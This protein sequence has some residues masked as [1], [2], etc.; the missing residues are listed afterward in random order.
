MRHANCKPFLAH[1][2]WHIRNPKP[3]TPLLWFYGW[4]TIGSSQNRRRDSRLKATRADG[5]LAPAAGELVSRLNL[6][7]CDLQPETIDDHCPDHH[8]T[9]H[10]ICF[11]AS[12]KS[13]TF[14][15]SAHPWTCTCQLCNVLQV[16]ANSLPHILT[17]QTSHLRISKK[18]VT[19]ALHVFKDSFISLTHRRATNSTKTLQI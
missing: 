19:A 18:N 15:K 11:G 13:S 3:L 9:R 14:G 4:L 7:R 6:W 10:L 5:I 12:R 2:F 17:L 16:M 1:L 8:S